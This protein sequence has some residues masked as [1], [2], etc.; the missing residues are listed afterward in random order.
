[1]QNHVLCWCVVFCV[2]QELQEERMA[3]IGNPAHKR[4]TLGDMVG[5]TLCGPQTGL[6]Y[7]IV[8]LH[9]AMLDVGPSSCICSWGQ[10]SCCN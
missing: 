6:H 2:L 8:G 1:L 7:I 10:F 9:S 3:N 4:E 5:A